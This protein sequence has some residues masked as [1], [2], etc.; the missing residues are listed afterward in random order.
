[1]LKMTG[2]HLLGIGNCE[3]RCHFGD[4]NMWPL[5]FQ[6]PE[7]LL[8]QDTREY[9]LVFTQRSQSLRRIGLG[10][11]SHKLGW[12]SLSIQHSIGVLREMSN[13]LKSCP[14]SPSR[15]PHVIYK[16]QKL[17]LAK[18]HSKC[19]RT[20]TFNERKEILCV[21]ISGSIFMWGKKYRIKKKKVILTVGFSEITSCHYKYKSHQ[22]LWFGAFSHVQV[23]DTFKKRN[24]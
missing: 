17:P 22:P 9:S 7:E 3:A 20:R 2:S 10:G 14:F 23:T 8:G 19:K 11:G 4:S 13:H 1:M 21:T 5:I 15:Q 6:L 16:P 12:S 18:S 24:Q